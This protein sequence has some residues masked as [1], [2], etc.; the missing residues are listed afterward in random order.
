MPNRQLAPPLVKRAPVAELVDATDSK[1]VSAR[2][3]SS[4]LTRG[5]IF[6]LTAIRY[7]HASDGTAYGRRRAV[8]LAKLAASINA[9][10]FI[11]STVI[12][13][14]VRVTSARLSTEQNRHPD[15]G[16]GPVRRA[17]GFTESAFRSRT[18]FYE[19]GPCLRT[20]DVDWGAPTP[21]KGESEPT[22]PHTRRAMTPARPWL[23]YAW[24]RPDPADR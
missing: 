1:S 5:T 19:L 10:P 21:I 24:R 4:S 18:Q 11:N 23:R 8:A 13:R 15:E 3:V 9:F 22:R 16:Q 6:Y 7:A 20:D 2:S 12:T 14:L 17:R